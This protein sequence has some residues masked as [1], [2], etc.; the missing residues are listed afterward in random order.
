MEKMD[1]YSELL[2]TMREKVPVGESFDPAA[3]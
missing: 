2:R 3:T 1:R